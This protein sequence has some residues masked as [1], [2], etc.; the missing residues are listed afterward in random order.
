MTLAP[1]LAFNAILLCAAASDIRDYRIP[2][3]LPA[4]L[5]I[6]GVTLAAPHSLGEAL[7]RSG[8]LALVSLIAGALWLRGLLGGGD[9][10]L[11][12]ACAVWIPLGGLP[13]FALALGLASGVQGLVALTFARVIQRAPVASAVRG[14]LPYGLSIAAA[15]LVW[16]LASSAFRL[17]A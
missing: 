8:S 2:N 9:L 12:A 15:G 7:S 13:T 3:L 10:K 6:A 5:A 17:A 1:L 11:L 16:S 14:R 4:L